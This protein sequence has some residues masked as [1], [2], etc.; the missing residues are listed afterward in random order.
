MTKAEA[1]V[2]TSGAFSMTLGLAEFLPAW[3]KRKSRH[4]RILKEQE[5][6][7]K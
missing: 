7:V 5:C 2:V 1:A 6:K 4:F 3:M